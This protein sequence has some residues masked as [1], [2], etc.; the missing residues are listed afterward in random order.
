MNYVLSNTYLHSTARTLMDEPVPCKAWANE[1]VRTPTTNDI[2]LFRS[3]ATWMRKAR[4]ATKV[5]EQWK[6]PNKRARVNNLVKWER[7]WWHLHRKRASSRSPI[8]A[9]IEDSGEAQGAPMCRSS[10][11]AVKNTKN[12]ASKTGESDTTLIPVLNTFK[13]T[14]F[15]HLEQRS[16]MT[17]YSFYNCIRYRNAKTRQNIRSNQQVVRKDASCVANAEIKYSCLVLPMQKQKHNWNW[18]VKFF[19]LRIRFSKVSL[20]RMALKCLKLPNF[21]IVWNERFVHT[22]MGVVRGA[23]IWKFQ[24]K[25]VFS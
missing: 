9:V 4:H 21:L 6:G 3:H 24:Q 7:G 1:V 14:T 15:P 2:L 19:I 5:Y 13:I 20:F 11:W 8:Q 12:T 17:E 25:K 16:I 23:G 18:S 22:S 10:H